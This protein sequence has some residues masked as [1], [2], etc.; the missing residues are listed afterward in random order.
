MSP[1]FFKSRVIQVLVSFSNKLFLS[2][3]YLLNENS[4]S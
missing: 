4:F 2:K 1:F 3:N